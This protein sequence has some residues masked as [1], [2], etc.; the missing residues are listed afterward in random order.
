[1]LFPP[2]F[3]PVHV[4]AY[5]IFNVLTRPPHLNIVLLKTNLN[6]TVNGTGMRIS[7]EI[8]WVLVMIALWDFIGVV[9]LR[10]GLVE[11]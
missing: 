7:E 10:Q 1:M 9:A 11:R 8:L 6:V 3:C 4:S 2:S 5:V